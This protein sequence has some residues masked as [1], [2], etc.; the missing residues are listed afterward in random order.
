M[1]PGCYPESYTGSCRGQNLQ[2]R[3]GQGLGRQGSF[4]TVAAANMLL[5]RSPAASMVSWSTEGTLC[6]TH[7]ALN[8]TKGK[9]KTVTL[10][11]GT[12]SGKDGSCPHRSARS[13][14]TLWRLLISH[15]HPGQRPKLLRRHQLKTCFLGRLGWKIWILEMEINL[16]IRLK[17]KSRSKHNTGKQ[18]SWELGM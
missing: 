3:R 15:S 11:K 2:K 14:S 13:L 10:D 4:I 18:R 17:Y 8:R 6:K 9:D 1:Q 12:V 5:Q 16:N 7:P